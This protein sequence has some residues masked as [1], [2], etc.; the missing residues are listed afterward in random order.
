VPV[1][2]KALERW[3]EEG[4]DEVT[5]PLRDAITALTEKK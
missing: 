5:D 3:E 1:L 2:Q 4:M